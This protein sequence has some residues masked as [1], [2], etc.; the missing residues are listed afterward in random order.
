MKPTLAKLKIILRS[1]IDSFVNSAII[2]S[3]LYT[4]VYVLVSHLLLSQGAL[5]GIRDFQL[6][7]AASLTGMTIFFVL[8]VA[9]YLLHQTSQSVNGIGLKPTDPVKAKRFLFMQSGIMWASLAVLCIA[10]VQ[11]VDYLALAALVVGLINWAAIHR[12]VGA[13]AVL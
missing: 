10:V 11:S 13:Y 8:P 1:N 6:T 3:L 9:I 2:S 7:H 4:T 12:T 5:N